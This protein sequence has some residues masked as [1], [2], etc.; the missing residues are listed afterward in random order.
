MPNLF[1]KFRKPSFKMFGNIIARNPRI[2]VCFG[3]CMVTERP[4]LASRSM[5]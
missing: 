5:G 2:L 4:L 3:I 1:K